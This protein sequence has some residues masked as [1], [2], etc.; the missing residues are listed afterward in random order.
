MLE[1]CNNWYEQYKRSKNIGDKIFKEILDFEVISINCNK[2]EVFFF[3]IIQ[4]FQCELKRYL[5]SDF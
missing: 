2:K 5:S 1:L 4:L 3:R